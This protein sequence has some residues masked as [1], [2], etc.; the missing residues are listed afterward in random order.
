M[1]GFN[2]LLGVYLTHYNRAF[3]MLFAIAGAMFVF[4]G[5]TGLTSFFYLDVILGVVIVFAGIH[6]LGE[7]FSHRSMRSS[8]DDAVRAI[9][10]LLQWAEKSYDYTR[11]FKDRHE[12]RIYRLDQKRTE[13]ESKVE[14]QFRSAVKKV[15]ELENKLNKTVRSLEQEKGLITRLDKMAKD[16]LKERQF[17]ERR[18]LDLSDTQFRALQLLRKQ[19]R[20][21]NK[22]YRTRFR[23]SDKRA[24]GELMALIQK[25]LIKR[26][27]KGRTTHYVLAF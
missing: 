4:T 25:G 20:L 2:R 27:G 7:E 21:T 26:Q 10:E 3:W 9:N 16:L 6:R 1:N 19:G 13:H 8:H 17:V 23:V 11:A 12:K 18:I 14:D 24:Y 5:I 15:I 22:D